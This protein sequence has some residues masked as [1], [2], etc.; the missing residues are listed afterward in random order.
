MKRAQARAA[1]TNT[2]NVAL[3]RRRW[4]MFG[5]IHTNRSLQYPPNIRSARS[6]MPRVSAVLLAAVAAAAD[7][8]VKFEVEVPSGAKEFTVLVHEDWS[9]I[10]AGRFRELVEAKFYDNTR[11]A[12]GCACP[13]HMPRQSSPGTSPRRCPGRWL[14]AGLPL[15][16]R[17]WRAACRFFRVL[18]SFMVQF[19]LNG[20]PDVSS[21]W[22]AKTITDEPVKVTNKPGYVCHTGP[23][24][25]TSRLRARPQPARQRSR[26]SCYSRV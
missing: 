20:D 18:P 15:A 26:Q 9:P 19:G 4:K 17:G 12:V 6:T 10:G 16:Y 3:L 24:P 13:V 2:W 25:R 5:A 7:F 21:S 11:C 8:R 22:R 23:E 1:R 14:T